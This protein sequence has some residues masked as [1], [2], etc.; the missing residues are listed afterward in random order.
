[1]GAGSAAKT[2]LLLVWTWCQHFHYDW[3]WM[4]ALLFWFCAL[5][6]LIFQYNIGVNMPF[7]CSTLRLASHYLSENISCVFPKTTFARNNTL[8]HFPSSFLFSRFHSISTPHPVLPPAFPSLCPAASLALSS[9]PLT[10]T[11]WAHSSGAATSLFSHMIEFLCG[12][13]PQGLKVTALAGVNMS[14]L[15]WL[16]CSIGLLAIFLKVQCKGNNSHMSWFHGAF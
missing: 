15:A 5:C 2:Q 14:W 16:L 4:C 13:Y 3:K 9:A 7:L 6:S 11:E 8:C 12:S 10:L 1:M